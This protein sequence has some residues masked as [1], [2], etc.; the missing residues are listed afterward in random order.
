MGGPPKVNK[1]EDFELD[2]PDITRGDL[3][4]HYKKEIKAAILTLRQS[5]L[6]NGTLSRDLMLLYGDVEKQVE[7]AASFKWLVHK[8]SLRSVKTSFKCGYSKKNDC[9]MFTAVTLVYYLHQFQEDK[10][11]EKK[12]KMQL[13]KLRALRTHGLKNFKVKGDDRNGY[14]LRLQKGYGLQS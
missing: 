3:V 13:A 7:V 11:E 9:V 14:Y 5:I 1:S 10:I 8:R 12:I 2:V 6:V 4:K